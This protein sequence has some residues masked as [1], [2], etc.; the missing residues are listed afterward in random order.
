[1]KRADAEYRDLVKR[2]AARLRKLPGVHLVGVGGRER[3]GE[4]TGQ[5]VLKVFLEKKRKP[6]DINPSEMI[7]A[8]IDGLPT[9]VVETAPF[10][11]S[12]APGKPP[13]PAQEAYKQG[14]FGRERPIKGGTQLGA[15]GGPPMP[16][17]LGFI[18]R[19]TGDPKRI[20]A[21]TCFHAI[22]PTGVFEM[23]R[24]CGQPNPEESST[25]CCDNKIGLC[26]AG[27]YDA[28]LDGA[29]VRVDGGQEWLA[30]IHQIGFIKGPHTISAAEAATLSYEV[31][32]RGRTLRLTGG[33][34]QSIIGN[35]TMNDPNMP[36][37][38]H[39]NTIVVKPNPSD[40]TTKPWFQQ[41]GDSGAALVNEQNE[42]TGMLF[43]RNDDGWGL[44]E[45]IQAIIDKFRTDD[46]INLE[47]AFATKLGQ[48][49]TVPQAAIEDGLAPAGIETPPALRRLQRDLDRTD[50]GRALISIWL[51]HSRELNHLVHHEPRVAATWRRAD[52]PGLFRLVIN[53]VD[54]PGRQ[55]PREI[56][57]VP[58]EQVLDEFLREVERYASPELRQDLRRHRPLLT[59][60]PGQSY[61]DLMNQLR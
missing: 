9:D 58:A 1:M 54:E 44:A 46:G 17:T 35:G 14:D 23:N 37:R 11:L 13:L 10:K 27:H 45:P 12:A 49:Q 55:V 42:I 25:K 56:Q 22:Y 20:M 38:P 59:M 24:K 51:Q 33:K 2:A 31:R 43:G 3:D 15:K 19:V 40:V 53:L 60:L 48:V 26:V 32:K 6:E 21:V 5:L 47:V 61:D 34:V 18:A 41:E 39:S 28:D 52:G 29:L 16:G 4:P 57:G 30:E 7:P 36:A 50:E 8:E